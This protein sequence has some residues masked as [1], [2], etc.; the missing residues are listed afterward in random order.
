VGLEG[1][2]RPVREG[3]RL[4]RGRRALLRAA[5]LTARPWPAVAAAGCGLAL[6][7]GSALWRWRHIVA[8]PGFQGSPSRNLDSVYPMV[9]PYFSGMLALLLLIEAVLLTGGRAHAVLRWLATA[10]A[11]A[12]VALL[13]IAAGRLVTTLTSRFSPDP[14]AR[15]HV[16]P[17][18]SF[19][20][21]AGAVLACLVA[22]WLAPPRRS[23]GNPP[24]SPR[25][26]TGV[27][28]LGAGLVAL[29][30]SLHLPVFR[31]YFPDWVRV[32]SPGSLIYSVLP[33]G[34]VAGGFAVAGLL[35]T[36]PEVRRLCWG[37]T[38]IALVGCG[39]LGGLLWL[40]A[41][42]DP[43]ASEHEVQAVRPGEGLLLGLLACVLIPL[44]GALGHRSR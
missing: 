3:R 18:P 4:D 9:A 41:A 13:G 7:V 40:L 24:R 15:A 8:D 44:G 32:D 29:A 2:Q 36:W 19:L 21:A 42:T 12:L 5:A 38:V 10:V 34:L 39:G 35:G 23:P 17:G 25:W 26:Y 28:V 33:T 31:T 1:R 11:A 20:L 37:W 22:A 6:L 43:Y 27:G 14:A 16:G 30:V